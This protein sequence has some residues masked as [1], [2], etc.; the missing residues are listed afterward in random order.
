MQVNL[1]NLGHTFTGK[2]WLF[3]NLNITLQP[4]EIYA[5]TGPSGSGKS[6]L[7]SILAGWE[8]PSE[9]N[10]AKENVATIRWVFQNPQ[11]S[12]KRT[13]EDHVMLPLLARGTPLRQARKETEELLERFGLQPLKNQAFKSLSGGERQRLMLARGLATN[14]DLFLIDE[15]T[16]QLDLQTRIEVNQAIKNLVHPGSIVVIATHDEE[17][18]NSCTAHIDLRQQPKQP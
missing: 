12:A 5:L 8:K 2:S 11:G 16:A 3:R 4:G 15:P 14:P 9:G 18:K 10:V 6:T 17:T 13:V 1:E 7:L